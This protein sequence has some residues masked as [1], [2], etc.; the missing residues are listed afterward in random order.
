MLHVTNHKLSK[1]ISSKSA[2]SSIK[3]GQLF[4]LTVQISGV[5][6]ADLVFSERGEK[7]LDVLTQ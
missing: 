4:G 2:H 3:P 1:W 5:D 7:G 6:D